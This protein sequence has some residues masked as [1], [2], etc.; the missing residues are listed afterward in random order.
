MHAVC[1]RLPAARSA[2]P[3]DVVV[4]ASGAFALQMSAAKI[5]VVC[6]CVCV[7]VYVCVRL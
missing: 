4:L 1:E 3:A 5:S 2:V 6:V 7:C